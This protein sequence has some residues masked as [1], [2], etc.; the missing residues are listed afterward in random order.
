LIRVETSEEKN[1]AL[2]L[3]QGMDRY[4]GL[5]LGRYG[6]FRVIDSLLAFSIVAFILFIGFLGHIF[7]RKTGWPDLLFL[8]TVGIVVG[9]VLN[10]FS[11]NDFLSFLP[12]FSTFTL[13]MVLFRGGM[14]L[15][16]LDVIGGSF[17]ALFQAS[18]YFAAGMVGTAVFVHFVMGWYWIESFMLGS[19]V[20]QTGAVVIVPLAKKIG[21]R[22]ESATLLSIEA[23]MTS[24]FNIIFFHAFLETRLGGI[25]NLVEALTLM[26]VKFSVGITVGAIVGI[27]WLWTLFHIPMDELMYMVAVGIILMGYIISERLGGS[28]SLTVLTLGIIIGN[29]KEI[30]RMIGSSQSPGIFL[31]VKKYLERV[32]AEISHILRTFFFVLLGIMFDVKQLSLFTILSYELPIICILL[33]I[34]YL[35]T[36]VS[37]W[38]TTMFRDRCAITGLCALGL[39]PALL[40]LIPMQYNLSNS[41]FYSIIVTNL[42]ILTNV[43]TSISALKFRR[44]LVKG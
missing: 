13:L 30:L 21:V 40:S 8:I 36:S 19:I 4:I 15:N 39:T 44:R 43:I 16:I 3:V 41:Q 1:R 6:G 26:I 7:F 10:I 29:D 27:L 31:E 37:T 35:V 22:S 5:T 2:G 28:G 14:E 38:K 11:K 18:A 20:S 33:A 17:R 25:L 42:I 23:T 24:I 32:Q 9:P 34:R 12:L